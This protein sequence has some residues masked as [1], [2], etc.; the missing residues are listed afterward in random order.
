MPVF[1]RRFQ[2]LPF[3]SQVP[4]YILGFVIDMLLSVMI[5]PDLEEPLPP[6]PECVDPVSYTHLDVYKRQGFTCALPVTSEAVVSYTA[7]PPLPQ[8]WRYISVALS[9][10]LSLIHI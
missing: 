9:L 7:I 8:K 4:S 1:K 10:E 2:L 6:P 5:L 3:V